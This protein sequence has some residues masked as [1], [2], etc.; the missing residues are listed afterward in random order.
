MVTKAR[1]VGRP[2]IIGCMTTFFPT[3]RI[4]WTLIRKVVEILKNSGKYKLEGEYFVSNKKRYI[5][6]S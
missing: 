6:P 3:K 5:T 1:Q 2:V 4:F